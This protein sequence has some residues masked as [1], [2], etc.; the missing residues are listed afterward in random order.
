MNLFIE[1]GSIIT[2]DLH[3]NFRPRIEHLLSF[4][5]KH[6]R[7]KKNLEISVDLYS[8]VKVAL[9]FSKNNE[10]CVHLKLPPISTC[11]MHNAS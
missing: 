8:Y 1:F 2:C 3:R 10:L 7:K 4:F 11:I 6:F 9:K 5:C